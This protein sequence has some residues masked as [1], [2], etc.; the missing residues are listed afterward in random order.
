MR[1]KSEG[2]GCKKSLLFRIKRREGRVDV[3]TY[4]GKSRSDSPI[5]RGNFTGEYGE[6]MEY[7]KSFLRYHLEGISSNPKN[8]V[9]Y[10]FSER[11]SRLRQP[12]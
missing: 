6:T 9:S 5:A 12:L 11:E 8:T 7:S 1:E 10:N 3:G 2:A 4:R